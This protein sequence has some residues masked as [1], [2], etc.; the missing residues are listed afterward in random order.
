MTALLRQEGRRV[1]LIF[2]DGVDR[3]LGGGRNVSLGAIKRVDHEDVMVY[4]LASSFGRGFG[5]RG[6][7]R[8][9]GQRG[10]QIENQPDP[11]LRR[12]APASGGGYFELTSTRDLAATFARVADGSIV[13]T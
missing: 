7:G 6:G 2:T 1:V 5:R 3:P 13:S 10:G 8:G 9:I 11:G 12:L 4:G